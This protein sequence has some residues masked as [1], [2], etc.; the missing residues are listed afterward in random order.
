MEGVKRFFAFCLA[1]IAFVV[2]TGCSK[3]SAGG[4]EEK[5]DGPSFSIKI[6]RDGKLLYTG[7]LAAMSGTY[8]PFGPDETFYSLDLIV[9]PKYPDNPNSTVV[10][11]LKKFD[12]G[13]ALSVEVCFSAKYKPEEGSFPVHFKSEGRGTE[14]NHLYYFGTTDGVNWTE[15][16]G[17]HTI[18]KVYVYTRKTKDSDG[19][20]HE[21]KSLYMNGKFTIKYKDK[22]GEHTL[23][24]EYKNLPTIVYYK[25]D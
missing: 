7:D 19:V 11:I 13:T 21:S 10:E 5:D 25:L 14:R 12:D 6:N 23:T 3:D 24:G 8:Y 17:Q 20:V 4:K 1:A 15:T 22:S 9:F 16:G 2:V 18:S